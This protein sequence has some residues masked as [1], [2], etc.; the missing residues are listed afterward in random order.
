MFSLLTKKNN[1][2][3]AKE[4]ELFNVSENTYIHRKL[5]L[6]CKCHKLFSGKLI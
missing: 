4:R 3:D 5:L 6:S 1:L 2:S